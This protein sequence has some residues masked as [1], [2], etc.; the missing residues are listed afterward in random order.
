MASVTVNTNETIGLI[1]RMNAVNNGPVRSRS[2]QS[3][4]NFDDYKALRIPYARIH[5]A[6]A[7]YS[8]G[9]PHTV[10]VNQIFTNFDADENDPASYDFV[11]TDEYLSNII[12]A[13]TQVFY[14]LGATIEH[15]IKKYNTLPP[16]NFEKWARICE[17]IIMHYN[18]GWADGFRWNIVY[19]EIW[20]EPDLD[21][22]D[23]PNKRC[24]GGT[25]AQFFDLY[26]ITAKHLKKRFPDLKIGGP[27]LAGHRDWAQD[28]ISA[29]A[30]DGVP[31]DFFSWHRYAVEPRQIV[32]ACRFYRK[33]LDDNGYTGAE[34]ILNEYNYVR[35]W[36]DDWIYSIEQ[37][38]GIK[39]GAFTAACM[40]ACQNEPLDMLMYYD[41]RVS[42]TMNCLFSTI[43]LKR[44]KGYY[45][46]YAFAELA[47]L[48]NQ[49]RCDSDDPAVYALAAK[50]GD[51]KTAI[52]ICYY[53]DDDNAGLRNV[54]ID[55]GLP[56]AEFDCRLADPDFS[57][58]PVWPKN[59]E[60][61]KFEFKLQKNSI[62][63]ITTK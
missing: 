39:G 34:S 48:G 37:M 50:G 21:P 58:E 35:G 6:G 28:F 47:D 59:R 19:W 29:M 46:F 51:G 15:W 53:T 31:M 44:L 3:K 1:K 16:K 32:D 13:G 25:K 40:C 41:A 7:C 22:D 56:D 60:G 8:Y 18:E 27:A 36:S 62:L 52:L 26:R 4:G 42:C 33:L 14:R 20:N 45:G 43:T 49:V 23:S 54:V 24:W 2:D 11:L 63:F 5:D 57:F 17:H 10:D 9:A 38:I 61:G 55:T 30:K 12:A